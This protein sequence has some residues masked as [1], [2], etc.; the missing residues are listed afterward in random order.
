M[1]QSKRSYISLLA[2][3][4]SIG[5]NFAATLVIGLMAGKAIDDRLDSRPWGTAVGALLGFLTGLWSVA[6]I[7]MK[8]KMRNNE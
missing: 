2:A 8:G 4:G 7:V 1:K 5:M 6:K 3:A